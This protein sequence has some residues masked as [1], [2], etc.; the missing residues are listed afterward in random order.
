MRAGEVSRRWGMGS[1]GIERRRRKGADANGVRKAALLLAP[2]SADTNVIRQV[3][4]RLGVKAFTA[5][6]VDLP[7]RALP[8][9]LRECVRRADLVVAVLED[10]AKAGNVLFELGFAQA[11][12][13]RGLLVLNGKDVPPWVTS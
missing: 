11:L 9:I 1:T 4:D 12:G 13:K 7:G 10:G 8:E 5:D 2:H 6:E 3:L